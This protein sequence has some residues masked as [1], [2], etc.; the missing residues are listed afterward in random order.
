MQG[1]EDAGV[2]DLELRRCFVQGER[3]RVQQ[4]K[5]QKQQAEQVAASRFCVCRGVGGAHYIHCAM[6]KAS[7]QFMLTL[8]SH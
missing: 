6:L 4:E 2:M 8:R 5:L 1:G 7:S 3:E